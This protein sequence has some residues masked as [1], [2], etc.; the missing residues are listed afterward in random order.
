M[1]RS[2]GKHARIGSEHGED[3]RNLDWARDLDW[4]RWERLVW[5][6][7]RSELALGVS[8]VPSKKLDDRLLAQLVDLA[9]VPAKSIEI[10]RTD[11]SYELSFPWRVN[12]EPSIAKRVGSKKL[13]LIQLRRSAKISGELSAIF[14]NLDHWALATLLFVEQ[15]RRQRPEKEERQRKFAQDHPGKKPPSYPPSA[16]FY[17]EAQLY[18][19]NFKKITNEFVELLSEAGS[20]LGAEPPPKPRGRPRRGAFSTHSSLAKFTLRLLLDVRVA[21]GRLSLD[22]NLREGTM[23]D[24]LKLLRPYLPRGFIPRPLPMA[25][26]NR[27]RTLDRKLALEPFARA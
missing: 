9:K 5:E 22:K 24:A 8:T 19:D 11:I 26:L 27:V 15:Q 17:S 3:Q 20:F 21:G 4:A 1:K 7:E 16:K 13:A 10:L 25:T 18:F 12:R 14:S 23:V 6:E 2:N